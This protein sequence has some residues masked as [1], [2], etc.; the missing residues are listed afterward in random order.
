ME[1]ILVQDN[2]PGVLDVLTECLQ[3]EGFEVY[4]HQKADEDVLKLIDEH[5]P[6]VVVL[7]YVLDGLQAIELCHLIKAKYPFLPVIALSCNTNIQTAYAKDGFD[8]YIKKP[9]DI[10]ILYKILRKHIPDGN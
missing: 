9:F 5:R 7:D 10:D 1:T 4:G 8:D 3:M 6:H 2:D